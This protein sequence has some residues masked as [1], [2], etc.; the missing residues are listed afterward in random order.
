MT[1]YLVEARIDHV[2]SKVIITAWKGGVDE[3]MLGPVAE[4]C[5]DIVESSVLT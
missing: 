2:V 3:D 5:R 1:R 4:H